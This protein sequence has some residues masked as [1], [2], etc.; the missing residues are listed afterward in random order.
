MRFYPSKFGNILDLVIG[1]IQLDDLLIQ[2]I[3]VRNGRDGLAVPSDGGEQLFAI[4]GWVVC[5]RS[6]IDS[7]DRLISTLVLF[8]FQL[9]VGVEQLRAG[10]GQDSVCV[11]FQTSPGDIRSRKYRQ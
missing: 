2:L 10:R 8:L 1:R 4:S 9:S 5:V 11:S 6:T 7:P 3:S